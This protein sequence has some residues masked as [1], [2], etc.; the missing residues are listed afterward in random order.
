VKLQKQKAYRL[1]ADRF[2]YKYVVTLPEPALA[3]LGWKEGS[4]LDIKVSGKSLVIDF[5][6]EPVPKEKRVITTKMEYNE[7]RDRIKKVL[8]Y[9]DKGMTWTEIRALLKLDQVVPNNK[10]V[11]QLENDIALHRVRG[12][13][14]AIVW[15][16]NHV[17]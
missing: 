1:D 4:E 13:D 8:E 15:R 10:W 16:V 2:Q 3:E 14:G 5:I 11:R 17:K 6:S 12:S 9:N 7:F